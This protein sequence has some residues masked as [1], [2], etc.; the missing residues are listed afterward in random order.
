M[1]WLGLIL[2]ALCLAGAIFY[3]IVGFFP[4]TAASQRMR[5]R[6]EL[7]AAA[8]QASPYRINLFGLYAWLFR[9]RIRAA[10]VVIFLLFWGVWFAA[11]AFRS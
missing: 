4:D 11:A 9:T 6:L 7:V 2:G 1:Q 10:F 3:F 8:G 5:G